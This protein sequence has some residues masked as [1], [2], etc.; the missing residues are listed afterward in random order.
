MIKQWKKI[1]TY[2]LLG[3]LLAT[4]IVYGFSYFIIIDPLRSEVGTLDKKI[5]MYENQYEKTVN[6]SEKKRSSE[7]L[8]VV[9]LQVPSERSPD[10]VLVNVQNIASNTN[11]T[12]NYIESG[13]Q[14]DNQ[15]E[16][17]QEEEEST[18]LNEN[19]YSLD[20]TASKLSDINSFLAEMTESKRLMKL[21]SINIQQDAEQAFLT[22]KFKTFYT[23]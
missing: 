23:G 6:Q 12:I 9:A 16:I 4:F 8:S 19:I 14:S 1:H 10:D 17:Q 15:A 2:F 13:N 22:V 11:V 20:A 3:I 21:E 18:E 5:S 7:E